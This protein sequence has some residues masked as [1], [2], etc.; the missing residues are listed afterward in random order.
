MYAWCY[1][2]YLLI[3]S[4]NYFLLESYFSSRKRDNAVSEMSS[5]CSVHCSNEAILCSG[6]GCREGVCRSRFVVQ[7]ERLSLCIP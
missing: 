4:V 3:V 2:F 7:G 6:L 5:G 1:D